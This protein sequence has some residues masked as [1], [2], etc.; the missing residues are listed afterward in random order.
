MQVKK[1]FW[2]LLVLLTAVGNIFAQTTFYISMDGNDLDSGTKEKP[3]ATL[4][5]ARDTIRVMKKSRPPSGGFIVYLRGG[6]YERTGSFVLGPE[7][8]GDST[9]PVVYSSYPGESVHIIGGKEIGGFHP[10]T[11]AAILKRL[12]P[13]ARDSVM[14]TDLRAQGIS[15]FGTMSRRGFGIGIQSSGLEL[16]F[17]ENPMQLARWPNEGWVLIDSVPNGQNG[18]KF[19]FNNAKV[20]RWINADDLWVH[21]YWTWDW[22][23]SYEKVKS[24]DTVTGEIATYPPH[25]VYGYTKGKRFYVLNVLEELDEPGEW[26]LDRVKGILYFW[27]PAP[28]ENAKTF[29]SL[30]AAPLIHFQNVHDVLFQNI[31]IE[32]TRGVEIQIDGGTHNRIAGCTLRNSGT[33]A[34]NVNGGTDNGVQS[35]DIY[36]TGGGGIILSGGNRMTLTPGNNFAENND[37]HNYNRWDRTYHAGV[38]INGVGNRIAHNAI[39]NAPHNAILLSGNDHVIEYNNIHDVCEEVGDAGAFYMGR[40]WTMRGNIVRYNYFHSIH[41]PYSIGAMGVYLDDLASGTAVYGNIFYEVDRGI[42]LGG[43]RDNDIENNIFVYCNPSIHIDARGLTWQMFAKGEGAKMYEKLE[44]IHFNKPPY[45]EHY[46]KLAQILEDDP[47]APKGNIVAYNI[48]VGGQWL[49]IQKS[50]D[51]LVVVKDDFVDGDPGFISFT[52]EDFRLHDDSQALKMGFTQIP[53]EKIGLHI[54]QWRKQLLGSSGS[55]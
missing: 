8:S 16:F 13:E 40:D 35:C 7:D 28:I 43:G 34:V 50:Y 41:G 14:E 3:F 4:E 26:Y 52:R 22:A 29:V 45:S 2:C 46:P 49:D 54:D 15:D 5:R 51:S 44:A 30:A 53:V 12:V 9:H 27:H 21:G 6:Y 10:V 48:S 24:I 55:K 38:G 47:G 31:I 37:I 17:D 1:Q 23:D 42:W 18:G 20:K 11:D 36:N 25:G 33:L 19:I 39:Y 32:Y